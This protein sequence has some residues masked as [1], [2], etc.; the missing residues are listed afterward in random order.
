MLDSFELHNKGGIAL[1]R[2]TK[3]KDLAKKRHIS[4]TSVCKELGY[5]NSYFLDL[6]KTGRDVPDDKLEQIA[7]VLFTTPAYLK[8]EIDVPDQPA[9]HVSGL[10]KAQQTVMEKV[11]RLSP[12]AL[13]ALDKML[14][15]LLS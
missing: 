5:A 13:E 6:S 11:K 15:Q 4:L 14:D 9:S 8:G 7:Q 2:I 12:E 3:I 1:D 10:T